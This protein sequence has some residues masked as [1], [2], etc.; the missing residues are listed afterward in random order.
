MGSGKEN[1][2]DAQGIHSHTYTHACMHVHTLYPCG[3]TES[4]L[5]VE[6]GWDRDEGW[7]TID[8][9]YHHQPCGSKLN[10]Y[11]LKNSS[12]QPRA[13]TPMLSS[14]NDSLRAEEIH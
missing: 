9:F 2:L 1:L 3:W 8:A 10:G 5:R 12:K 13:L 14:Q 6:V 4:F 11:L 7:E